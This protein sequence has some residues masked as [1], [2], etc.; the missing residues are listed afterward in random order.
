[1]MI[2]SRSIFSDE[3]DPAEVRDH[4]LRKNGY[5]L[6]KALQYRQK[7]AQEDRFKDIFYDHF[8]RDPIKTLREIYLNMGT[9]SPELESRF[10]NLIKIDHKRKYGQHVYTMEGFGITRNGIEDR[11]QPYL[12]F[13]RQ[14][15]KNRKS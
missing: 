1:M 6:F 4:W 8:I 11:M 12:A 14:L 15:E 2:H 3:V 5:M 13:I 9:I 10:Q 7:G